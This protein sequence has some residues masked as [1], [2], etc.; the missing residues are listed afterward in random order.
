MDRGSGDLLVG[1]WVPRSD[2]DL[3]LPSDVP[4]LEELVKFRESI[5]K[6]FK[7]VLRS[8]ELKGT[9]SYS[10][11][12]PPPTMGPLLYFSPG[13]QPP[14]LLLQTCPSFPGPF[15]ITVSNQRANFTHLLSFLLQPVIPK[16]AVS[17]GLLLPSSTFLSCSPP[18]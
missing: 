11:K 15:P 2:K 8:Y 16:S 18:N 6:E 17:N 14:F 7:K 9:A 4:L 10:T 12:P 13:S 1:L 5:I 3:I